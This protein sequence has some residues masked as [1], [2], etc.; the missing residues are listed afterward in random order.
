MKRNP[1]QKRFVSRKDFEE[2]SYV[3]FSTKTERNSVFF[4]LRAYGE[5]N[6]KTTWKYVQKAGETQSLSL[7]YITHGEFVISSEKRTRIFRT[8][9]LLLHKTDR[10]NLTLSSNPATGL[11]K[12]YL[13]LEYNQILNHLY[14]MLSESVFAIHLDH[15]EDILELFEK[16]KKQV[17]GKEEFIDSELSALVYQILY[18]IDKYQRVPDFTDEMARIL[19]II[20]YSPECFPDLKSLFAEFKV[21]H[22][23]LCAFFRKHLHT[24]PM[25]YVI[26][27]RFGKACWHLAYQTAP[28]KVIA[29]LCGFNNVPFFTNSFKKR[30]GMTPTEF[31]NKSKSKIIFLKKQHRTFPKPIQKN[32]GLNAGK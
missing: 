20:E 7:Q 14:N 23:K 24:S 22:Y 3:D 16:I 5:T 9:D 27:K 31:R 29:A 25:E 6:A 28:V 30:Y 19:S 8:G 12:I 26:E 18:E 32:V 15:P 11:K 2:I 4:Q 17:T 1:F 13:C 21:S 10:N